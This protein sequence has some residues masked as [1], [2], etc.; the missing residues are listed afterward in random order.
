VKPTATNLAAP[1]VPGHSPEGPL[2]ELRE[3][4]VA[5]RDAAEI[6]IEGVDWTVEAGD[7]WLVAGLPGCGKSQLLQTAAG[8]LP[9]VRGRQRLFGREVAELAEAD[10]LPLRHRIG[11]VFPD[12]GRL[13]HQLTVAQNVGLP[14]C[15]LRDCTLEQVAGPVAS[16]LEPMGLLACAN[17]Y[18]A[19]LGR[20]IR[21]RVAVAR[22]LALEPDVLFLDNPLNGL[23]AGQSR[24]WLEFVA[25]L[26]RRGATAEERPRAVVVA[27]DQLRPWQGLARRIGLIQDR[28]WRRFD[29]LTAAV[30]AADPL[31]REVLA[32]ALP[33]G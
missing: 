3:V 29:D 9:P 12:G 11:F 16:L 26:L 23:D 22:A 33:P 4:A 13:F 24:W 10:Y 15:Y 30:T 27:V 2:V 32:E 20:S 17:A 18:P 25:G 31:V 21:Q 28:R 5:A 6:L 19:A 14:L 1:T 7:F 8:L